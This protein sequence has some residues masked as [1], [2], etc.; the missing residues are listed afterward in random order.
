MRNVVLNLAA[1]IEAKVLV[2]TEN[3]NTS[4]ADLTRLT[5][6]Y[7]VCE[8]DFSKRFGMC[9]SSPSLEGYSSML[10][11]TNEREL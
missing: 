10:T 1:V 6:D 2:L 3:G 9:S 11:R 5:N 8:N 7:T 4:P